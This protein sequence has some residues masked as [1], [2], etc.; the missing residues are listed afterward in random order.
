[1]ILVTG[2]TGFVGYYL[3]KALVEKGEKVR[4]TYRS[5]SNSKIMA[6]LPQVEWVEC[7][8]LD[9]FALDKVMKGI[10]QV[11]HCAALVSFRPKD[12][13]TL[14]LINVEGSSNVANAA[15]EHQV[16]KFL[17]LSS[18]AAIGRVS[19]DKPINEA[20]EWDNNLP[21]SDYA[22]TKYAGEMEV[23]RS[24]AEGLNGVIV[25]PSI[26]LG[27]WMWDKGSAKFFQR[28]WNN[29]KFYTE[30]STGFVDVKDVVKACILL[31]ESE[32]TSERFILSAENI[33]YQKVFNWIAEVLN[34]KP[35]SI[36]AGK[37]LSAL[38]WRA[39]AVRSKLTQSDPLLTK[40]SAQT[41][42]ASYHFENA[43]FLEAFPQFRYNSI[44]QCV[45]ETAQYFLKEQ[46]KELMPLF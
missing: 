2:G 1:M 7:D 16:K 9:V 6:K 21:T 32:I 35:A 30:G 24:M 25:N 31:M 10:E 18:V 13:H 40:Y 27:R 34:K 33:A 38:V 43:K 37:L 28:A 4:A 20:S 41:A 17:H 39:E 42:Q 26:I 29:P 22:K 5:S 44:E 14:E 3:L 19:N 11:Y 46:Q 45:K 23:W 15:L 36:K 12:A 8:I